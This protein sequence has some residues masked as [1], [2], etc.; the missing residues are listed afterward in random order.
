MCDSVDQYA[1]GLIDRVDTKL[2]V[3]GI[4]A[5]R[6]KLHRRRGHAHELPTTDYPYLNRALE[7]PTL[8]YLSYLQ[9]D[10]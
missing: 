2:Q 10:D 3:L 5:V 7:A 6:Q 4:W 9:D 8:S 1:F